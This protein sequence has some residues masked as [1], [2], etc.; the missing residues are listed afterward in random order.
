MI[1]VFSQENEGNRTLKFFA[2]DFS[3]QLNFVIIAYA[4]KFFLKPK[5]LDRETFHLFTVHELSTCFYRLSD[6][7][8]KSLG[9]PLRCFHARNLAVER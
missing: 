8:A 1:K 3:Q 2:N 5:C 6:T 7:L 4:T 9:D